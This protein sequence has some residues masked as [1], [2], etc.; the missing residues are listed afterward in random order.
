MNSTKNYYEEYMDKVSNL[1]LTVEAIDPKVWQDKKHLYRKGTMK[2]FKYHGGFKSWKE[3][4]PKIKKLMTSLNKGKFA[5]TII[6]DPVDHKP[7]KQ[8][9]EGVRD[10]IMFLQQKDL[11]WSA[12]P[13]SI[14][15]NM[16]KSKEGK[17]IP[18]SDFLKM[19]D[20]KLQNINKINEKMDQLQDKK[21]ISSLTDKEEKILKEKEKE[22]KLLT[23]YQ[24]LRMKFSDK[25]ILEGYK[26]VISIQPRLIASQSTQVSWDSCMRFDRRGGQ[27]IYADNPS[28]GGVGGGI[29]GGVIVAYLVKYDDTKV[30]KP[31]SRSL[32]KPFKNEDGEIFWYADKIYTSKAQILEDD[33]KIDKVNAAEMARF[34]DKSAGKFQ[35]F[36]YDILEPFNADLPEDTYSLSDAIYKDTKS[37]YKITPVTKYVMKGDFSDLKDKSSK[38]LTE[39]AAQEPEIINKREWQEALFSHDVIDGDLNLSGSDIVVFGE[40]WS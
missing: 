31:I 18:L 14:A 27:T 37:E 38:F 30:A 24:K 17:N 19:W 29:A 3:V 40:P 36:L 39:L 11:G 12:T 13:E 6:I 32:I 1:G 15:A 26:V 4:Y 20:N 7:H 22:Y 28:Q 35:S 33:F 5:R 8:K 2:T 10:F 25:N 16:L 21:R 34:A 9:L 23:E